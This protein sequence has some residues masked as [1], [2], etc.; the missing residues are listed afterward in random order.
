METSDMM[1]DNDWY[2]VSPREW[3]YQHPTTWMYT[4]VITVVGKDE[5]AVRI[6]HEFMGVVDSWETAK[7]LA[8]LMANVKE[9]E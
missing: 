8:A 3:M 4:A 7:G 2:K 9:T 1:N 6:G 5:W